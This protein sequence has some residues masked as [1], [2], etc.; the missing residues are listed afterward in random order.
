MKTKRGIKNRLGLKSYV[1]FEA[2]ILGLI[3]NR[4]SVSRGNRG[5]HYMGKNRSDVSLRFR[6][7]TCS[8]QLRGSCEGEKYLM[9]I[10]VDAVAIVAAVAI[11]CSCF[12][13]EDIFF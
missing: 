1:F 12:F 3:I 5:S 11:V 10:T 13:S 7:V 9:I 2:F 4:C 8:Q 6:H